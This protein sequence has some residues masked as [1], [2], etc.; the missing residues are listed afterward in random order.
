M[1]REKKAVTEKL[2]GDGGANV[3][4]EKAVLSLLGWNSV[5]LGEKWT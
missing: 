4:I 1:L 3:M 5:Y 2:A